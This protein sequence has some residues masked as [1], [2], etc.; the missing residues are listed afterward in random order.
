MNRITSRA[1]AAFLVLAIVLISC[2][3][4]AATKDEDRAGGAEVI[5][6]ESPG[7]TKCAASER[8]LLKV[9]MDT[10]LNVS[11]YFYYSDAGHRIIKQYGSKDVPSIIIGGQVIDYRDYE[12]DD[13]LLERLIRDALANLSRPVGASIGLPVLPVNESREQGSGEEGGLGLNLNE[14]SAYSISAVLGAGL[15][16]GFNPCLLG[17][18]VFLAATVLSSAGKK[19]DLVMMVAFFSAGIFTTYFLFGLGMQRLME[20][21]AVANAFRYIL[22]AFLLL[23]GISQI[24]D[25]MRLR[26]AK[27]S[28]FRTDWALPYFKAGVERGRYSSYFLIGALFSLVK[29]PCV[30]AIYL[31]ILDLFSARSYLVGATYLFFFNLGVVLPILLLGSGIA[32]GMSPEQVD[33]FRKEHRVGMRLFTGLALLALAP[34]IYWEV[35]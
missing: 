11:S 22:T 4:L 23:A 15:V 2:E 19:R 35:I 9:G 34:L 21:R 10:P 6:I 3:A 28:I 30:G 7:C 14:I 12:K 32:M 17:I 20:A 29:A 18:L 33:S 5:F 13:D 25:G 16:A 27:P 31:A 8:V 1:L 24:W 26:S